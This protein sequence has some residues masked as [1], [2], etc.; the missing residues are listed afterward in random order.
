MCKNLLEVEKKIAHLFFFI[1]ISFAANSQAP[2]Q[3]TNIN[4]VSGTTNYSD[5]KVTLTVTDPNGFPM[6]VK[7][8]GRKKTCASVVPNFTIIGLPDTQFYTEEVPGTNSGGGGN[9][10]ILKAQTQW[11]AAHRIDSNIAFV[12]QLGDCTQ[13]GDNPPGTDK[14]IEWKRA[15]TAMQ[16]IENP[17]VPLTDGIP[18]SMCVGNHDETPK[19][20]INGTTTFYNQ[21][22]GNA[23]FTGRGYY[24][25]RY[26]TTNNNDHFEL[27]TSGGIDFIHISLEYFPDGTSAK[28]QLLLNW[29]D[30]LLKSYPTRKGILSSHQLLGTGNPANFQGSGQKI[31]DDLK[32]N[33]NLFLMLCGHIT[34]DGRRSDTYN[35][36][37]IYTLMSDYQGYLNGGNGFLRI[38]QFRPSQ[39]IISVKTYSPYRDSSYTG[40]SSQFTIP[41]NTSCP[42][43]LI[44]T[45]T[46]VASGSSTTFT[47]PGLQLSTDYEWYVTIDDGVKVTTSSLA[48]FTTWNG[49]PP[50]TGDWSL[51]FTDSTYVDLGNAPEL[52]LTDFTLEAWVKI[53]GYGSTTQTETT[54]GQGFKNVVPIITKGRADVETATKDINYFLGYES[55]TNKLVADFEDNATS[56]NHP[57]ISTA[58][59]PMN[60]WTHVGASFD[61]ATRTW[62]LFIGAAVESTVLAG[63]YTPQSLSTVK[64]CIGSTLNATPSTKP[65]SFNGRIDEVRI[66]NTALTSLDPGEFTSGPNLVGKWDLG[67]G[68]GTTVMNSVSGGANGTIVN[69]YEWVTGF[70][71]PDPTTNASIDFNGKHDYVT[72]GVAPSLNTTSTSTG[73]TLEGWI[74]VEGAGVTTSTGT[75]G[76][77]G[78]SIPIIA[79][80]R[81]DGDAIANMNV[82][83]FLGI[84]NTR[85]LQADFEEAAGANTGLN[86][87]ITAATA[88]PNNVWT[89]VA[90]TYNISDGAW[91]LYANGV[92]VGTGNAGAGK[93]PEYTSIEHASIGSALTSTGLAGGFFNG[94]IDEVR[95]WDHALTQAEIQANMNNQITSGS[96]LLGRW[97]FNENGDSTAVNSIAGGVNGILRS[98]N[99]YIDPTSG[100][101][102]WVSSGFIPTI[103]SGTTTTATTATPASIVYGTTSI[104][105][106]ATV[107]PNPNAGTV[108]FYV[109]GLLVGADVVD[110][111]TGIAKLL[112]YDPS[113]LNAGSHTIRADF[114]GYGGFTASTGA[115]GS[116]TVTPATL[117]Y[118]APG[119][120]RIYGDPNPA[121]TGTVIGFQNGETVA[122]ATG[123]TLSFT[124]SA[125][126][127]SS[128]GNYSINGSGLTANNGNYTFVQAPG[129]STSLIITDAFLTYTAN[130]VTRVY[131]DPDPV[132]SGTVS[133]FKNGDTTSTATTGTLTF[134]SFTNDSSNVGTYLING[135]GLIANNGNYSF[136]EAESNSTA[137]TITKRPLDF[138]GAR[139]FINGN[140]TFQA[141]QLTPGNV[142]NFDILDLTGSATVASPNVGP[143]TSFVTNSLVSSNSNYQVTGGS[144][145]VSIETIPVNNH[146]S[147]RFTDTSY[148]DLGNAPSLHLTNFTVEA[149]IKIEGYA[150]TTRSGSVTGGG[151][152]GL[153]PIICKGRA[154][155]DLAAVDVNYFLSYR[156]SDRKLVADFE[157]GT[158]LNHSVTSAATLPMNTWVHVGASFEVASQKWRLFIDNNAAEVFTL[159]GGPFTPQSISDV[160]ACIGSTLNTAGTAKPG[161][162]NGRIDEVRIWNTALTVLDPGEI[163]TAQPNLVGRWSFDEGSGGFVANTVISGASGTLVNKIEWVSGFNVTD[164]TTDASIRFN[165]VHDYVTFGAAP[166]LNTTAFTL[167][168]WIYREGLGISTNSGS[169][170]AVGVPIITKGRSDNDAPANVNVNY[171]LGVNSSNQ[172]VGDFEEAGG[173]NHPVTGT[174]AIPN[175]VWTHVAATYEPVTA[176]WNLYVNGVLDKTLDIGSNIN[177]V[178][179]SI[180]HA[181]IGSALNST[182]VADGFFNGKI[183]EV[184]IWNRALSASELQPNLAAACSPSSTVGLLGYWNFNQNGNVTANNSVAGGVNGSLISNNISTIPTNGGPSW[185]CNGFLGIYRSKNVSGTWSTPSDWEISNGSTWSVATRPPTYADD[186][187][188]STGTTMKV[189]AQAFCKNLTVNN[190]GKLFKGNSTNIYISVYGHIVCNGIIGNGLSSIDG[191]SFTLEGDTCSI[192]GNGTIDCSRMRK[193]CNRNTTTNLTFNRDV[194]LRFSGTALYNEASSSFFNIKIPAG[195]TVNCPGDGSAN[196]AGSVAIHY[197]NGVDPAFEAGSLTIDGTLNLTGTGTAIPILYLNNTHT[198]NSPNPSWPVSVTIGPTGIINTGIINCTASTASGHSFTIVSGGR[199]NITGEPAAYTAPSLTNNNYIL[200]SGSTIEYS[201]SGSQTVYTFGSINYS[202]L[203]GSGSGIKS[204]LAPLGVTDTVK[205]MGTATL[206]SGGNLT[207][208]SSATKT[209]RVAALPV[210]GSGNPLANITGDVTVERYI[211]AKRAWRFLSVPTNTIQSVKAAWQEGATVYTQNPVPGYGTQIT[212]NTATLLADGFDYYS[213]DGPSMKRYNFATNTYIGI[214]NTT[215]FGIATKEGWMTFVRG[216]RRAI[217]IG[218]TPTATVLRTKGPLFSGPQTFPINAGQFQGVG[219]PYAAPLD[220]RQITKTTK[221]YFYLWDPNLTSPTGLGAFQTFNYD[222]ISGNYSP[223]PGG[224]SYPPGGTPYNYIQSGL[225]FFVAGDVSNGKVDI[226]ENSKATSASAGT[227]LAFRPESINTT[228]AQLRTNLYAIEST[229]T[230]LVDGTLEQFADKY[231]NVV[232]KFDAKKISNFSENLSLKTDSQLLVVERR[233]AIAQ[234]DTI[235]LNMLK[236]KVKSYRF[237]FMGQGFD[238]ALTAFLE[239]SY[240]NT[241]VPLNINGTSTYDFTVVNI[242]GSWNPTRFRIVFASVAGPLPITF[243]TIKAYQQNKNVAVEWKVENEK[244]MKQYEVEKSADGQYFAL[245]NTVTAK[246]NNNG[247]VTYQWLDVNAFAGN[248]Y[249]RIR[250]VSINGEIK[251]SDIVKVAI[252]SN[253]KPTIMIYPNPIVDGTI[254]LL[255]INQPEGSYGVRLINEL[256]QILWSKKVWHQEGSSTE[257]FSMG[258]FSTQG[259]YNL[260]IT[261]PDNNKLT[262]KII[263][264]K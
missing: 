158:S 57:V 116:F 112:T 178:N 106:T 23:R 198:F 118:V 10:A 146:K 5:N 137:L 1:L 214:P 144:V 33:S 88:I 164:S 114:E 127:A 110:A 92:I 55:G 130:P 135:S 167:E 95:I 148:V 82:N 210:D 149:W 156:L 153:I 227:I 2:L 122:T 245:A 125:T 84:N 212:D 185:A 224:G 8:Y 111:T 83:Y 250:S 202:N 174:T 40:S 98:H 159:T 124:T 101:P 108:Q 45:N 232:D 86:H 105:F 63:S 99:P 253:N 207:L 244:N 93:V 41:F 34:G 213:A 30:S 128:V 97:G 223:T 35:G 58:K 80:G 205:L 225:A 12:V 219:N 238:P 199:L 36:N 65:G 254:N 15:D 261:K 14:Q 217:G 104:S 94:K 132:F 180:E 61:V 133:G 160:N 259:V 209:A 71:D 165:G 72:F 7:L 129:N 26:G 102:A 154:E 54:P 107:T 157:D 56:A 179:T 81:A 170:G 256:G 67:D 226:I 6:T 126:P 249:Y 39:S 17:N 3:P 64:A 147:I 4:P 251:Y 31:Y 263:Y 175:N 190:G 141:S 229:G 233:H 66:W 211:S 113:L 237:E 241:R 143:Y 29:A 168:G 52:R 109:D 257:K 136:V 145:N 38:M 77:L 262:Q 142:V 22:F 200:N 172:L 171:F 197:I 195:I 21:Y 230:Y 11:I 27:F 53:E 47:W 182:G 258:N 74:K 151:Q 177:P 120:S 117:T 243:S 152:D 189:S 131:G 42:F 90:A 181:A 121:F 13:N 176:V 173:A 264:T 247:S 48:G 169:G 59:I 260:E 100:G 20:N 75:T 139:L 193:S 76:A 196:S 9:N 215:S 79:K 239:D 192:S 138:S 203:F 162:F 187:I 222:I 161:F 16:I 37:T 191:I 87:S 242:P 163:T 51:R 240:Y 96:G 150:S 234:A 186:V 235:Q 91:N 28:L 85:F 115:N 50:P 46:S 134:T 60:T 204:I 89:H 119:I 252:G 70:N 206:G 68:I 43:T 194:I 216:D 236:M 24:G 218:A 248:N 201:R 123:G 220:M 228:Q 49:V 184:R 155:Q 246:L 188:I 208:L 44:G 18:Y 32:N 69:N 255:I 221:E 78:A 19:D 62:R 183:D 140:S 103:T 73:F 166:T 231:S 25:G